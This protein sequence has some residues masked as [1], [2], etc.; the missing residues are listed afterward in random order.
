M[1]Y[2]KSQIGWFLIGLF[3][4]V[5]LFIVLAYWNQWGSKPLSTNPFT[6]VLL[7]QIYVLL[8]FYK[9]TI[10]VDQST[11]QLHYGIAL[12]R[13]RL[14]ITK[15]LEVQSIQT[16]WYYGLGIRITPK[17]MLYNIQGSNALKLV[18]QNNGITKKVMLGTPEPDVL[19]RYLENHFALKS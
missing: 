18:Y 10:L 8:L 19:K 16:P 13:I 12:I 17:G 3:G 5:A 15:L 9:L 2:R 14:K 4:I 11:I 7:I 1:E 6:V